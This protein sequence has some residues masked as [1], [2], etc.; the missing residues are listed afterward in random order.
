MSIQ[1]PSIELF[2]GFYNSDYLGTYFESNFD[3][4]Q[5]TQL[6]NNKLKLQ[7]YF[8]YSNEI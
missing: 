2:T 8:M 4:L 5:A 6:H 3:L 1:L 7:L